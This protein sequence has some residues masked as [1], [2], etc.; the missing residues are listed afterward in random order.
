ML[1][2]VKRAK[3]LKAG[4]VKVLY[5]VESEADSAAESSFFFPDCP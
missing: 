1:K 3:I 2:A 4:F 5:M